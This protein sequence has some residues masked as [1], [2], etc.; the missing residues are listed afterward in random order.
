[1]ENVFQRVTG[2]YDL[3]RLKRSRVVYVDTG[4][5]AGFEEDL[6]RAGVG[7]HVLI[8]PDTVFVT[9]LATQQVYRRNVGRP[10]VQALAER[11]RDINP[12]AVVLTFSF[13][14]SKSLIKSSTIFF[15][16]PQRGEKSP[17]RSCCAA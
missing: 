10:K 16:T 17:K 8:D 3:E 11:L 15:L 2:A 6:V 14:L 7:E 12:E 9:N 4:G 13:Q 5:A 1:M